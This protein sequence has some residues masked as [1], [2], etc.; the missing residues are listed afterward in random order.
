MLKDK[1]ILQNVIIRCWNPEWEIQCDFHDAHFA[2]IC[3]VPTDKRQDVD[4]SFYHYDIN[5]YMHILDKKYIRSYLFNV[6]KRVCSG[7]FLFV[8]RT[9]L[10]WRKC[11]NFKFTALWRIR[12]LKF[13]CGYINI[14]HLCNRGKK[15]CIWFFLFV[16]KVYLNVKWKAKPSACI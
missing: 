15:I 5:S 3:L 6:G 12:M 2:Y 13:L 1:S 9:H 7:F 14:T 10:D 4:P 8:F 11:I 16:C